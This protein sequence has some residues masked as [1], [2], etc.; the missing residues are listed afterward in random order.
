MSTMSTKPKLWHR[1]VDDVLAIVKRAAIDSTLQHLNS[2]HPDIVFTIEVESNG[3]LPYLDA[4]IR[5]NVKKRKQ[6]SAQSEKEMEDEMGRGLVNIGPC[7]LHILH[8][9]FRAGVLQTG[10]SMECTLRSLLPGSLKI[11]LPEERTMRAS[12]RHLSNTIL[13]SSLG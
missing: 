9:A 1:Y 4:T 11:H 7:G 3:R 2:Q 8:N 13:R 6:P 5:R 10:W 12:H